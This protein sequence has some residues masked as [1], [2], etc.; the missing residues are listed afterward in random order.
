MDKH[1]NCLGFSGQL[2]IL[3]S[4]INDCLRESH[5]GD[6]D[7]DDGDAGRDGRGDGLQEGRLL[8]L[9]SLLQ[10][11]GWCWNRIGTV[12]MVQ[13]QL[14]RGIQE[15]LGSNPRTK[16]YLKKQLRVPLPWQATMNYMKGLRLKLDDL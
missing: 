12:N 13:I 1:L 11:I 16:K 10:S 5:D 8:K 9:A 4:P 6:D 3:P 15:D 2:M 7:G 14:S